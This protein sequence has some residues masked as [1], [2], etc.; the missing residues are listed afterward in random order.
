MF[1]AACSHSQA[2]VPPG[3]PIAAE[4][5]I[6]VGPMTDECK[7]LEGALDGY[8]QCPNLDDDQR[9]WIKATQD[10]AEQTFAAGAKTHPDELALHAMAVACKK[11]ATS[12]HFAT[13][14][15]QA[16]K[17]PPVAD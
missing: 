16:G 14:R 12:V 17:R 13:Q 9:S 3:P 11:A 5:E 7:G 15:C 8:L 6:A 4:A 10:F 1:A 2:P